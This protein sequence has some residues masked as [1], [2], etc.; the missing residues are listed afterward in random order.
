MDEGQIKALKTEIKYLKER[1]MAIEK[2][3]RLLREDILSDD[4]K[5]N[6]QRRMLRSP[7]EKLYQKKEKID[8]EIKIEI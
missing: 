4:P 5:E 2:E 6:M 1:L 7:P 8:S 3:L